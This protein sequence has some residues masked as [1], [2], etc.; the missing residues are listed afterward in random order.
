MIVD[1]SLYITVARLKHELDDDDATD[2]LLL[3]R[4]IRE[5]QGI[6]E[7]TCRRTFKA[8]TDTTVKFDAVDD[9]DGRTLWFLDRDLCRV[10]SLVN[11]DGTVITA[12]KYVFEPRGDAP[13]FGLTLKASAGI[14]WTYTTDPEDAISLAGGWAFSE[15]PPPDIVDATVRLSAWLYRQRDSSSDFDRV[16]VS[17]QSGVTMLPAQ[18]PAD[19][20]WILEKRTKT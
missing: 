9:V 7:A 6:I 2:D 17:V 16:T 5:A 8:V 1:P 19:V 14:A 15:T 18:I 20:R 4:K 3:A 10:T 12:D 11:G 13:W